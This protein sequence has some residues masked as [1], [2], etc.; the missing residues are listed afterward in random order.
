[1]SGN[2]VNNFIY[3]SAQLTL[4]EVQFSV[5]E[6]RKMHCSEMS[7]LAVERWAKIMAFGN[8]MSVIITG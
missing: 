1:V 3:R 8:G 5:N 7:M 4:K 6:N 2:T